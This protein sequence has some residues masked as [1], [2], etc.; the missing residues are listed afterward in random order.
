MVCFQTKN[1]YLGK[2]W[3]ALDFVFIWYIISGFWYH[4]P[5]KNL[6]TLVTLLSA[7]VTDLERVVCGIHVARGRGVEDAAL[8]SGNAVRPA[9][10]ETRTQ[11]KRQGALCKQAKRSAVRTPARV[12]TVGFPILLLL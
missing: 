5:S 12:G 1:P 3:R 10:A 6:A 7:R 4:I 11:V 9:V 8:T 2:F